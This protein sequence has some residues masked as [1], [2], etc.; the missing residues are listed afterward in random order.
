LFPWFK[1]PW[2]GRELFSDLLGEIMSTN[3]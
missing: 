2:R 3:P 1:P